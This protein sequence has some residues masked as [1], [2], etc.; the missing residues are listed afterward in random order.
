MNSDTSYSIEPETPVHLAPSLVIITGLSGAGKS[1]A[2]R[3][4]DDLGYYCLDNLPPALILDFFRLYMQGTG[5][6]KGVAIAS[7]MRSGDLFDDFQ[8]TVMRLEAEAIHFAIVYLDCDTEVLMKRFKEVRRSHPLETQYSLRRAIVEERKQLA[9]TLALATDVI[10]TTHMAAAQLRQTVLQ[11][12]VQRDAADVSMIKVLSFG[13]KYGAPRD[14]DFVFD[15]RFLPNPFYKEELR[16]LSGEDDPVYTYVM[17]QDAANRFFDSIIQLLD[18]TFDAFVNVG[19]FSINIAFGCTGGRHRSVAFA[20]RL[21]M[22]YRKRGKD[23]QTYHRD[24]THPL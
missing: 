14:A 24:I 19:K 11:T 13:F 5:T 10:D 17:N 4:F 23:V 7:D 3:V 2:M 9:A 1:T 6:K 20:K 15:V 16:P 22:Y 18:P 12:V 21:S 8:S